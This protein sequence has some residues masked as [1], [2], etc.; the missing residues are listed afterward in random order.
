MRILD[1]MQQ[2]AAGYLRQHGGR[3]DDHSR[4]LLRRIRDWQFRIGRHRKDQTLAKR[5][6]D[7]SS[8]TAKRQSRSSSSRTSPSSGAR[9]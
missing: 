3:L 9:R 8:K 1:M 2:E 6:R 7:T 4:W 5:R